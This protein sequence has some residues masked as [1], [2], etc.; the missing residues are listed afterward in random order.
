MWVIFH[1]STIPLST[2]AAV[3]S[4]LLLYTKSLTR[5]RTRRCELSVGWRMCVLRSA[6]ESFCVRIATSQ[7]FCHIFALVTSQCQWSYCL[8]VSDV[9]AT[10]NEVVYDCCPEPYLDITFTIKIRWGLIGVGPEM[11]AVIG[12]YRRRT[13]YYFYNLIVPCLLISSMA[14]LDFTLPPDSGEKL[15]LGGWNQTCKQCLTLLKIESIL[16][17]KHLKKS[18]P[19]FGMLVTDGVKDLC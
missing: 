5:W 16:R 19:E 2:S 3:E 10:R 11:E 4:W 18:P 9:P 7:H 15:S 1:N 14:V 6:G 17:E 13:L 12:C 8:P